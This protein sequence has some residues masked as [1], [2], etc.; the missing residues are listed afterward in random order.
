M[1]LC[2]LR[3]A[4][5]LLPFV[6]IN[7]KLFWTE[8]AM[9]VAGTFWLR[10]KEKRFLVPGSVREQRIPFP[11]PSG[12]D[13]AGYSQP[14]SG[15][16]GSIRFSDKS[17]V[18][19]LIFS[20][21]LQFMH[22][23]TSELGE[24]LKTDNLHAQNTSGIQNGLEVAAYLCLLQENILKNQ[25]KATKRTALGL[26]GGIELG[27]TCSPWWAA[28][29]LWWL[30]EDKHHT[31]GLRLGI[32]ILHTG[33][34]WC[35][36][37][38]ARNNADEALKLVGPYRE[39]PTKH[40]LRACWLN[41]CHMRDASSLPRRQKKPLSAIKHPSSFSNSLTRSALCRAVVSAHDLCLP[42]QG[43]RSIMGS[44]P[45]IS[46]FSSLGR[47]TDGIQLSEE[48]RGQAYPKTKCSWEVI[49]PPQNPLQ[50][51]GQRMSLNL[52]PRA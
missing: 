15:W 7:N 43:W 33:S 38:P 29:L 39:K 25:E 42:S 37:R 30:C 40:C 36:R 23:S 44:R 48:G 31:R 28:L 9:A 5:F 11:L 17:Y 47:A 34:G 45:I 3:H 16:R 51:L 4:V 6:C 1:A 24:I 52:V 12:G 26:E 41:A 50:G 13:A 19:L 49:N 35:K 32:I 20:G 27:E 18:T 14:C 22:I 46:S 2:N 10:E 8:E 21:M